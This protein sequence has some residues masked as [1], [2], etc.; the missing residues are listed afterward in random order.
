VVLESPLYLPV[1]K[2]SPERKEERSKERDLVLDKFLLSVYNV[3]ESVC[4]SSADISGLEPA[5]R[6]NDVSR[7]YWI[8][9]I[10]LEK[11]PGTLNETCT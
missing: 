7:R 1:K 10:A 4:V 8:V 6:S 9:Q 3:I 11:V 5:I 2:V